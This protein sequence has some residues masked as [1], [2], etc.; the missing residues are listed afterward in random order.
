MKAL[1]LLIKISLCAGCWLWTENAHAQFHLN[2]SAAVFNDSCWTLTTEGFAQVGSIWNEDKINLNESFQVIMELNF[3]CKDADGADG[4]LFGFQP[5]STSIGQSGEGLGFQGVAPSIGIEFDTWQNANLADPAF[6]HIAI[7]RDGLLNHGTF[8]NLAGPV[9]AL[10]G[11]GNI[12]NCEWYRLRVNWDAA[13]H[14]L[15]VWFDCKLALTYTGDIVNEIFGGNPEVFWGFTAATGGAVN[16]QQ[17]CYSYTTFLDSFDDVVICPGGQFQLQLGGGIE[18]HWTPSDGLS[19][20]NIPNPIAKPEQTTTYLVEV[21]D[22]CSNTFSDS[23]TVFVDGDTVFFDLGLD[24]MLCEEQ[25]LQL[26]AT[27]F[28][29][30]SVDYQW[31]NGAVTPTFNVL[32]TGNYSVTVTIDEYCHAD[33]R[34]YV[35]VIPL[36]RETPL[37]DTS[38]C[39]ETTLLLDA[40]TSGSPAYLWQDGSSADTILVNSP[41]VYSVTATNQ[42]GKAVSSAEIAYED[43]HQIYFPNAFSPD[44]DGINDVFL[45]FDGGDVSA[46]RSLMV[47]SR[48]GELVFEGYNFLPGSFSH[49]W[50]GV[51]LGKN[52]GAGT[53]VWWAEVE[54]RDGVREIKEGEVNLLR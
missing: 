12:E 53:Y 31:Q 24:T 44:G 28:G 19:N 39:L 11:N 30:N 50:N 34:V 21:T 3:G 13:A 37:R 5:L 22:A 46:V 54:F 40:S 42:C 27:S 35:E 1:R 9:A 33:D 17:V 32:S 4:I 41:G 51:F 8:N 36:P 16:L 49:G 7:C 6:D 23:L 10:P 25:P 29:T 2:G 18:Y 20:P 38:L 43:C 47:F 26:D 14:T 48:W 15:E 45:P 52:A